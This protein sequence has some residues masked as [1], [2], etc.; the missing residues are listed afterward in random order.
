MKKIAIIFLFIGLSIGC[1]SDGF[2]NRNPYIPNVQVNWMIDLTLPLYSN[3]NFATNKATNFSQGVRGV[4]VFSLGNN[5]FVAFEMACPNQEL[6]SCSTMTIEGL[7]AICPCDEAEYSLFTGQS[8]GK[9][10]PLKQYRVEV[11]GNTL[12]VYN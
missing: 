4:V 2:N 5:N 7:N 6:S 11:N 1:E 12:L 9:Q 3:L 10:Y 8:E